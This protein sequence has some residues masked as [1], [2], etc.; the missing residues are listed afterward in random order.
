MPGLE[1]VMNAELICTTG[2]G[3]VKLIT[4]PIM[5]LV[6]GEIAGTIADGVA[7]ANIPAFDSCDVL[8]QCVPL[9][10]VW[11]A[12]NPTVLMD[13]IPALAEISL[14]PCLAAVALA[15]VTGGADDVGPCIVII[16]DPNNFTV[17]V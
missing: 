17:F 9:T 15:V 16:A 3:T 12:G 6:E 1:T 8:G 14:C 2:G 5:I 11:V 13:G 7:D 10:A 4:D